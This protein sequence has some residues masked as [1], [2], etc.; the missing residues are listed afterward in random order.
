MFIL[1][2][3]VFE[4]DITLNYHHKFVPTCLV[5]KL[6]VYSFQIDVLDNLINSK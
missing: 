1:F 2:A 6:C 3:F 5:I 4:M